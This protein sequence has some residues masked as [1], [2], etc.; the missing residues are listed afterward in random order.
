MSI[1]PQSLGNSSEAD[2]HSSFP[3]LNGL[4]KKDVKCTTECDSCKLVKAVRV[5]HES[6]SI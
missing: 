5:Q 6:F 2:M 4:K 3:H 1:G